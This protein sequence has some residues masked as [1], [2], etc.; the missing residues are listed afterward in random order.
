[1]KSFEI[2]N[3]EINLL[4]EAI[5]QRY[6]HDFRCYA[7]ASIERRVRQF[8]PESGCE[9]ISGMIQKLMRDETFFE[10]I[11]KTFSITVTEMFRDPEVYRSI[12]K[13]VVPFLKTNPFVRIWIAG[14]ATGEEAYSLAILLQEEGLYDRATI[15]ATDFND[16]SLDKAREGI[17][18]LGNAKQFTTNYQQAGGHASFSEYYHAK[19]ESM[20]INKSLKKRITFANHNLVVDGVFGEMQLILCRN[21]LI[22]FGKSLQDRVLNLFFESL[23]P[24]GILCLGNKESLLFSDVKERFKTIDDKM[25]L[26][27]KKP[28]LD[29]KE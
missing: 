9:T 2:E 8:L 1:M 13:N 7:R 23:V 16:A 25:K 6:G 26:Y 18:P 11:I 15:F 20:A 5:F 21:V 4:L 27:K 29:R 17:Y 10:K 22:Y 24:G 19:Y 12:R 28:Y 3:I 14:C